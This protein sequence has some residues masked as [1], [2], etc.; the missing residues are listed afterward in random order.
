MNMWFKFNDSTFYLY[1]T[2]KMSPIY[3]T[4]FS[5]VGEQRDFWKIG[6]VIEGQDNIIITRDKVESSGP[7]SVN[8]SVSYIYV[9]PNIIVYHE[10][11]EHGNTFK[12][13]EYTA[14]QDLRVIDFVGVNKI[15]YII[16]PERMF[17]YSVNKDSLRK[18][19]EISNFKDN[20]F[21]QIGITQGKVFLYVKRVA[22]G[23]ML[24]ASSQFTEKEN[25]FGYQ[26]LAGRRITIR[27]SGNQNYVIYVVDK[28][29][30]GKYYTIRN[31]GVTKAI[32]LVFE[33]LAGINRWYPNAVDFKDRI[34]F[35]DELEHVLYLKGTKKGI[36]S[37]ST[38]QPILGIV[39]SSVNQFLEQDKVLLMTDERNKQTGSVTLAPIVLRKP[40]VVCLNDNNPLT[41]YL[42]FT[43]ATIKNR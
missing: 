39:Y 41:T 23:E 35:Y 26:H 32:S 31:P 27:N 5:R 33:P 29:G 6:T 13:K 22:D 4:K 15:I 36:L 16:S 38:T 10:M 40:N 12:T 8:T 20:T 34:H 1:R 7:N 21:K 14:D 9:P 2:D 17:K 19:E 37:F 43:V 42:R 24:Y 28:K 11:D 3:I 25:E 18:E 30:D